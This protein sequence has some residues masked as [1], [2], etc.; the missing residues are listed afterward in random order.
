MYSKV[1]VHLHRRCPFSSIFLLFNTM[2][3][4]RV[5]EVISQH[6]PSKRALQAA[7]RVCPLG[8]YHGYT[9]SYGVKTRSNVGQ[10][11]EWVSTHTHEVDFGI[12]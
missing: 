12:G 1:V 5:A 9:I 7:A 6:L 11:F 10:A 2:A 8:A 3:D 4:R